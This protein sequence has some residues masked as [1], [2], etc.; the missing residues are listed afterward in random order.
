MMMSGIMPIAYGTSLKQ[1]H[2][3][4]EL[5]FLQCNCQKMSLFRVPTVN[6]SSQL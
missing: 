3:V 1:P 2:L 4:L 5:P 6:Y